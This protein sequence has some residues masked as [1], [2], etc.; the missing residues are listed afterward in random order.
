VQSVEYYK[1]AI[2]VVTCGECKF[3]G[4]GVIYNLFW[5]EPGRNV[6]IIRAKPVKNNRR[7]FVLNQLVSYLLVDSGDKNVQFRSNDPHRP[8]LSFTTAVQP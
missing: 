1:T 8:L 5:L 2:T 6:R 7:T 3:G 4:E